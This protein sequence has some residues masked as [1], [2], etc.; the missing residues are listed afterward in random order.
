MP[1]SMFDCPEQIQT[2]P[3][4][5]SLNVTVFFPFTVTVT[6]VALPGNGVSSTRHFPLS[7]AWACVFSEPTVTVT[8]SPGS[9]VPQT[10]S[11]AP[12]CSTM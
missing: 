9:A 8:A 11:F 5:T 6:G 1:N 3:T 7:S 12:S 2:S 10:G 4:S